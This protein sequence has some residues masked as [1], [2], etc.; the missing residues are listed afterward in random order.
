M[1]PA[2]TVKTLRQI[3]LKILYIDRSCCAKQ[4]AG[5]KIYRRIPTRRRTLQIFIRQQ[6]YKDLREAMLPSN[7][8]PCAGLSIFY[9]IDCIAH[10]LRFRGKFHY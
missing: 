7:K 10:A 4:K 8:H 2:N 6:R 5:I 3:A 1:V 9:Y